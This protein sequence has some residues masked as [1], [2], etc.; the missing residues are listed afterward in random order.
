MKQAYEEKFARMRNSSKEIYAESRNI[1]HEFK[2]TI[3]YL[4]E[5]SNQVYH[6]TF[7]SDLN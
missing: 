7:I 4:E 1:R 3:K 6:L 5:S 2:D